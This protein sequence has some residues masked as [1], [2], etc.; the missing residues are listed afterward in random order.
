M[1]NYLILFF[2]PLVLWPAQD[3]VGHLP[4]R[5]HSLCRCHC[6]YCSASADRDHCRGHSGE[7]HEL[8]RQKAYLDHQASQTGTLKKSFSDPTSIMLYLLSRV[9]LI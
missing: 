8:R 9:H 3:P 1:K 6:G 4:G 7:D 2:I 5:Y